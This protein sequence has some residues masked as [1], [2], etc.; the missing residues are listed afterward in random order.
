[1]SAQATAQPL[2]AAVTRY[3]IGTGVILRGVHADG[4]PVKMDAWTLA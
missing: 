1:V 2:T 3:P 4:V